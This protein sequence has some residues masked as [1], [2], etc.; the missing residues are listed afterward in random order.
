MT[1]PLIHETSVINLLMIMYYYIVTLDFV[2]LPLFTS[3][4]QSVFEWLSIDQVD[5]RLGEN[6]PMFITKSRS[7]FENEM[8]GLRNHY[9]VRTYFQ[10]MSINLHAE[11]CSRV[12]F[13]LPHAVLSYGAICILLTYVAS[14]L[15]SVLQVGTR[16]ML[17]VWHMPL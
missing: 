17:R 9:K 4:V 5:D 15:G 8:I 7:I 12:S 16:S 11:I 3:V 1:Y 2:R 13:F 6:I 10:F 14:Y